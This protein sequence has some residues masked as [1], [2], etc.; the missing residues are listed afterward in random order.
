DD[1]TLMAGILP[2]PTGG[3]I[4][5]IV[6]SHFG[7]EEEGQRAIRPIRELGSVLMDTVARIPYCAVQQQL[8]ASFPKGLRNYWK[9]AFLKNLT[10]DVVDLIIEGARTSPSPLNAMVIEAYGGAISRVANDATAF[11]HRDA[12]LNLLILAMSD[13]RTIDAEQTAW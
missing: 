5:G 8:D 13:N 2:A 11:G 4:V 12:M 7:T 6:M 9:S 10:D 1:L 3:Q